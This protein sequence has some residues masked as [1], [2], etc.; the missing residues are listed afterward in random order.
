[1]TLLISQVRRVLDPYAVW[2]MRRL[3]ELRVDRLVLEG[4]ER[5]FSCSVTTCKFYRKS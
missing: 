3:D 2:Q 5:S 4:C 1:M